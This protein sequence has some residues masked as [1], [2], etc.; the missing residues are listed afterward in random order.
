MSGS[1]P[2]LLADMQAFWVEYDALEGDEAAQQAL[3]VQWH[4]AHGGRRA[5]AIDVQRHRA[6]HLG[7]LVLGIH[8]VR[9]SEL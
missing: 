1:D 8:P 6:R 9:L 3:M 7:E 2:A 4:L 5:T